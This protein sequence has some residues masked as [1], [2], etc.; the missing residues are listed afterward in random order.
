MDRTVRWA[1]EAFAHYRERSSPIPTR[2]AL[3][4]DRAGLDVSP[5]SAANAPSDCSTSMPTVTRS[6]AFR[7]ASRARSVWRWWKRA[8]RGCRATGPATPWAS[9]CRTNCAE[10][11]ARGID[12]MDCVLPSRNARNGWLFTSEGRVVIK[13]ARYRD[14][15]GP[16]DPGLRLLHLSKLF[17]GLSASFVSGGGNPVRLAGHPA[18]SAALP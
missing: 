2:H 13:H 18:Q 9:A 8:N 5:I 14:D 6:A 16:L 4:P 12:M 3:V 11:V 17:P 1:E 7:S 10:Y 15:A